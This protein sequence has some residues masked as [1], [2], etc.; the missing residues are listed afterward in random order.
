MFFTEPVPDCVGQAER[1]EFAEHL[2][3]V[4]TEMD[5]VEEIFLASHDIAD[6]ERTHDL[7]EF[8]GGHGPNITGL[9][10]GFDMFD[11]LF[12]ILDPVKDFVKAVF[13]DEVVRE[14]YNVLF[15][16]YLLSRDFP[17]P[18]WIAIPRNSVSC[19]MSQR[20]S[21]A[22]TIVNYGMDTLYHP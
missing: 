15:H 4:A 22:A 21:L 1:N 6:F 13:A 3:A 20:S 12:R 11:K 8:G 14:V 2:L 9:E 18:V 16:F 10:I 7:T 19:D 17:L 5:A